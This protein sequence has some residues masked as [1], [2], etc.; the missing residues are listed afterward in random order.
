MVYNEVVSEEDTIKIAISK[1]LTYQNYK[2]YLYQWLQSF[3]FTA[4]DDIYALVEAQSGKQVFSEKYILLKDRNHLMLFPKQN[5]NETEQFLIEKD[6][7]EVKFPL[8]ISFCN[9]DDVSVQST[10]TIFVDEDTLQFPLEIR[11]WHEGD[12]F[13]PHGM[14]GKKK[15]SKFFKDEKFSVFDKANTWLLC[16]DNQIIWVIGNRADDRYK[17]TEQT[18]KIVQ[19]QL[20]E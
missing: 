19:I 10:N 8:K 17:T 15:L 1:L 7:R 12:W 2:A 4:W 9:V 14:N 20:Q 11:K 13:Y 18:T 6:Q 5:E 16:S 3:G